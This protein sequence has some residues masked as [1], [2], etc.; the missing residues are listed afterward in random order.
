MSMFHRLFWWPSDFNTKK[1][2]TFHFDW[3]CYFLLWWIVWF[4]FSGYTMLRDPQFNKGLAFTEKER[5]AH[6][7]R[8]LLPPTVICQETQVH[9][10]VIKYSPSNVFFPFMKIILDAMDRVWIRVYAISSYSSYSCILYT[11]EANDQKHKAIRSSITEV[12]GDDGS[13]GS[14]VKI[15]LLFRIVIKYKKC[16]LGVLNVMEKKRM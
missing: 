6:Y 11:G 12:H 3:L 10:L 5:D 16:L 4:F 7:L 1:W 2:F 13:S 9:H 15:P 14:L 8:G